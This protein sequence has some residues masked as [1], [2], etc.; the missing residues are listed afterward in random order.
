MTSS[1]L[2]IS[3]YATVAASQCRIGKQQGREGYVSARLN[4]L[5]DHHVTSKN[6]EQFLTQVLNHAMEVIHN[7]VKA[8]ISTQSSILLQYLP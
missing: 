7:I 3:Q 4:R 6:K 1:F 2:R 5:G 8:T